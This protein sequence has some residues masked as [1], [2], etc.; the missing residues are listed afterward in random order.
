MGFTEAEG[1][2]YLVNKSSERMVHGFEVTQKL[3][4]IVL[5]AI[6]FILKT[7]ARQKKTHF[8]AETTKTSS[9]SHIINYFRN[10]IKG[11]K[12]L[13][14]RIWARSFNNKSKQDNRYVYLTNVR[15]QIRTIR[16]IRL[17]K[18]FKLRL[19]LVAK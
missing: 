12:S 15:E 14:Y 9:I 7:N 2:F 19:V 6:S 13:E 18:S 4:F 1:S 5:R 11:I 8:T 16:S 10:T 17:D 3:D